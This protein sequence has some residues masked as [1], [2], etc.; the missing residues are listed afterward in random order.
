MKRMLGLL[1]LGY[2]LSLF[3]PPLYALDEKKAGQPALDPATTR[4]VGVWEI[5]Q[6]KAP[7]HPYTAGYKGRPFVSKGPHAFTLF[8]E[9][10]KDG[11]FRRLTRVGPKETAQNGTWVFS[12]H[13]LRHHRAG[14]R[15]EEV[16]YVRFD[17]ADAY[18]ST[19]VYEGTSDPGLFAQF[20]RVK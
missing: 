3:L 1:A 13:E 10:N 7:G 9:Y 20:K 16:M 14:A 15:E 8:L 6:T 11:T 12:G 5:V 4:L 2:C 18:T 17:G 19:E